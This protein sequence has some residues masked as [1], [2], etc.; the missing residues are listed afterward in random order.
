[1]KLL[2]IRRRVSK[3]VKIGEIHMIKKAEGKRKTQKAINILSWNKEKCF[4]CGACEVT[5]SLYHHGECAPSQAGLRF[6][7]GT[8]TG[9]PLVEVCRQCIEP[10]CYYACPVEGALYIDET[11]GTRAINMDV[12]IGCGLCAKACP[13]NKEG[14]IIRYVPNREKYFKCNLCNGDPRCTK[15]CVVGALEYIK[16]KQI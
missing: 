12:C 10:E 16:W 2:K 6:H 9:E 14:S 11:T 13:F 7:R 5:C 4:G 15:I 8:W 1:M 3:I